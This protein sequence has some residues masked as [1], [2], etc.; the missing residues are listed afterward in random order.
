MSRHKEKKMSTLLIRDNSIH[1]V[2]QYIDIYPVRQI[3]PH[4]TGTYS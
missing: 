1:M 3:L 4:I 2:H